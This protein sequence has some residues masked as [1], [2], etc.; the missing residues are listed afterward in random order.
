MKVLLTGK[1][2]IGKTTVVKKVVEKLKD[3]VIGFW[4]EDIRDRTG[5]R[6]GFKIITTEGDETILA[7]VYMMDTPYTVGR[8]SVD[9]NSFEKTV[10]PVLEKALRS[11]KIV[12]IDEIGKMELFSKR[13]ENLI[14]E[15]FDKKDKILATVPVKNVHPLVKELKERHDCLLIEVNLSNRNSLPEKIIELLNK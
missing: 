1:P 13:F 8:Y 2:G 10:I 7:S 9:I 14:R 6:T 5:R 15:I 4:T 12:V 11:E 3:K